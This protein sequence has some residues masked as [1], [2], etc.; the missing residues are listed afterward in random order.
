MIAR[1]SL[2]DQETIVPLSEKEVEEKRS[3]KED[4]KKQ[5]R[6]I[7]K[8]QIKGKGKKKERKEPAFEFQDQ[9]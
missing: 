3:K 4:G 7:V 9:H 2:V 1:L 8:D 6:L 5:E